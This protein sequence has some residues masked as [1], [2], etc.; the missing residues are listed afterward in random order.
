MIE[1]IIKKKNELQDK[2]S[3]LWLKNNYNGV[4]LLY[5]GFGKNFTAFKCISKGLEKGSSILWAFEVTDREET[6][7]ADIKKFD[8]LYGTKLL[9]DYNWTFACYQSIYKWKEKHFNL[10][11]AD[12]CHEL[13]SLKRFDFVRNNTFDKFIGLTAT[14]DEAAIVDEDNKIT[15]GMLMNSFTSVLCKYTMEDGQA[16]G[17]APPLKIFVLN[18]KLDTVK[19]SINAGN[20]KKQ[21]LQTEWSAYQYRNKNFAKAMFIGNEKQK[22]FAIRAASAARA[23]L[24]YNLPSKIEV[25]KELLNFLESF[26]KK[27]IIFGN[28]LEALS[29]VTKNVVKGENSDLKNNK[30][31]KD[32]EKGKINNIASFKKL[33]QGANIDNLDCCIVMSYYTKE[34]DYIQRA[35]RILRFRE[36]HYPFI[37]ILRT[38]DTQ[39]VK[40][41]DEMMSNFNQTNIE[42]CSNTND[43]ITKIKYFLNDRDL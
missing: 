34:L 14:L 11:C 37:I 5:T 21:F 32:F 35:G 6:V 12:E 36:N 3:D 23:K 17:I 31:K 39:E 27:T 33:K 43:C 1:E 25:T 26:G 8:K 24:L 4:F 16:D 41:F 42:Y 28:S 40:W 22:L 2:F 7:L 18:H 20:A 19:K 38:V 10:F 29:S 15:K 13:P 9:K 30:I